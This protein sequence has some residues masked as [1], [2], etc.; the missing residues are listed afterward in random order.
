MLVQQASSRER[1]AVDC[2][3]WEHSVTELSK[4]PYHHCYGQW[5]TVAEPRY[6]GCSN[7]KSSIVEERIL[8]FVFVPS[9]VEE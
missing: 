7:V 3:C 4:G 5:S 9:I 6:V 1:E 2:G 8:P